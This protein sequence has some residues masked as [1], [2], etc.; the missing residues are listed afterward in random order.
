[1]SEIA[2]NP[3]ETAL[4]PAKRTYGRPL[5]SANAA[6]MARLAHAK[7]RERKENL[8][9]QVQQ[10]QEAQDPPK[11]DYETRR[12]IRVRAQLD[13]LDREIDAEIGGDSKRLRE[14]VDAQTRLSEQERILSGRP[15]PGSLRPKAP[16]EPKTPPT[17]GISDEF[18]PA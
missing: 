4:A 6:E 9:I 7:R 13:R 8:R 14:L 18:T 2:L 16:K 3:A 15:M 10:A 11:Y 1:M 17:S 5:T 12:L